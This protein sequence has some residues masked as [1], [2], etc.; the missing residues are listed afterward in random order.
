M[1]FKQNDLNNFYDRM[2]TFANS[3]KPIADNVNVLL[4]DSKKFLTPEQLKEVEAKFPD[5]QTFKSV[6]NSL[7]NLGEL[8]KKAR[9]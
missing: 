4:Q 8:L 2:N 1:E 3:V 5:G 7:S 9:G 6:N